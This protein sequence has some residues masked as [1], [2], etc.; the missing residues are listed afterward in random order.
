M[1]A[2]KEQTVSFHSGCQSAPN[3]DVDLSVNFKN[4]RKCKGRKERYALGQVMDWWEGQC[5][6]SQ[7]DS[8][9]H[10]CRPP[11]RPSFKLGLFL[12]HS[13]T[14]L[15]SLRLDHWLEYLLC[16]IAGKGSEI[17]KGT[18]RADCLTTARTWGSKKC[19][20]PATMLPH[21]SSKVHKQ[22]PW[23]RLRGKGTSPHDQLLFPN[24]I[25]TLMRAES[26]RQQ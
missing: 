11:L 7:L 25:G 26:A 18:H 13:E 8:L 6:M 15:F 14:V 20:K 24:S 23:G 17:C 4:E 16:L 1:K 21:S 5:G 19:L 9:A 12:A 22:Q 10:S 3:D 2:W